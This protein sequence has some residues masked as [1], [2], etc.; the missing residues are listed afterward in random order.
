MNDTDSDNIDYNNNNI[1][2]NSHYNN[3][4][5][6]NNNN[7]DVVASYDISWQKE[8]ELWRTNTYS[9]T[10]TYSKTNT[11]STNNTNNNINIY[12]RIRPL[13]SSEVLSL[14]SL[15][16]SKAASSLCY[17]YHCLSDF[18]T[19]S[20]AKDNTNTNTNTNSIFI[21]TEGRIHGALIS[22]ASITTKVSLLLLLLLLLS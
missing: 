2:N 19:S 22:P 14:G 18:N 12:C 20:N 11:N 7:D 6:N 1:N 5:N 8:V 4:A 13:L 10:N 15:I 17:E 9:A 21:H 3:I 16:I